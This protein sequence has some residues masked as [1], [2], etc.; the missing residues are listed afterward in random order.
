GFSISKTS[1]ASRSSRTR[2]FSKRFRWRG[3]RNGR[4]NTATSK[5][6]SRRLLLDEHERVGEVL[7]AAH[8]GLADGR[9]PLLQQLLEVVLRLL[10]LAPLHERRFPGQVITRA[11]ATDDVAHFSHR[12]P[13]RVGNDPVGCRRT[14][15]TNVN[16]VRDRASLPARFHRGPAPPV[17]GP[18]LP[19]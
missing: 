18:R 10:V 3:T 1:R 5:A 9:P 8:A 17:C 12:F 6:S 11:V 19:C 7:A 4:T 15:P 14:Q 13:P 16:G 2:R